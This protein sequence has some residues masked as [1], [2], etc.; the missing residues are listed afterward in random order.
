MYHLVDRSSWLL[1][2][3]LVLFFSIL[4]IFFF[5]LIVFILG[6]SFGFFY[7]KKKELDYEPFNFSVGEKLLEKSQI[8]TRSTGRNKN[9]GFGCLKPKKQNHPHEYNAYTAK[10]GDL[11]IAEVTVTHS[12]ITFGKKNVNIGE[13]AH[14]SE[15]QIYRV[16][17]KE[18]KWAYLYNHTKNIEKYNLHEKVDYIKLDKS[19]QKVL[20]V[21]GHN[22]INKEPIVPWNSSMN[23][24]QLAVDSYNSFE[25]KIMDSAKEVIKDF[26]KD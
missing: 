22:D 9:S 3:F 18:E 7:L 23:S 12:G 21:L 16:K 26:I 20:K 14:I 5:G 19:V 15:V 4:F 11:V 6:V 2:L 17:S 1:T 24:F 13:T 10:N 25:T 8:I